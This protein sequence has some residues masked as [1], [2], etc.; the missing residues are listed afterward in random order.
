MEKKVV[1][2]VIK[3]TMLTKQSSGILHRCLYRYTATFD[4]FY[5]AVVTM[6]ITLYYLNERIILSL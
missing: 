4:F 5:I 3:S 1:I 2:K 6:L